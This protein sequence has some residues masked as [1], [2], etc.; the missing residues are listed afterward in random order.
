M[1]NLFWT[2]VIPILA[3]VMTNGIYDYIQKRGTNNTRR[4]EWTVGAT[5]VSLVLC[6]IVFKDN[7]EPTKNAVV[8]TPTPIPSPAPQKSPVSIEVR[9]AGGVGDFYLVDSKILLDQ[10]ENKQ[11]FEKF[12]KGEAGLSQSQESYYLTYIGKSSSEWVRLDNKLSAIVDSYE[13]LPVADAV[14]ERENGG[15][16]LERKATVTLNGSGNG[17]V[18][19]YQIEPGDGEP[20]YTQYTLQK[21]EPEVF[22]IGWNIKKLGKYTVRIGI[23][24]HFEGKSNIEWKTVTVSAPTKVRVWYS[25]YQARKFVLGN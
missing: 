21:G 17:A 10:Q 12:S 25:D 23:R 19:E 11:L 1:D 18:K 24:Y 13:P 2:I 5:F 14:T 8:P 7:K 6:L 22:K 3:G 4:I 16:L 20:N 15:G 9:Q